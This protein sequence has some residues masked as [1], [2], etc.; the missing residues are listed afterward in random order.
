MSVFFA[1]FVTASKW[2]V[3]G[4]INKNEII[5]GPVI[6]NFREEVDSREEVL[7]LKASTK[8]N[9]LPSKLKGFIEHL[10]MNASHDR[11]FNVNWEPE[12]ACSIVENE[13]LFVRE[14]PK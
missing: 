2:I 1:D 4:R 14:S 12:I 7:E 5:I 3:N 13:K 9:C 8:V 6:F 11:V 10:W